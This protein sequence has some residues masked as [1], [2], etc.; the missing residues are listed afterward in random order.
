MPGWLTH[1]GHV[2]RPRQERKNKNQPR[3]YIPWIFVGSIFK[4]WHDERRMEKIFTATASWN[5]VIIL[6]PKCKNSV[7]LKHH[8]PRFVFHIR[9]ELTGY[10]L[11]GYILQAPD[12]LRLFPG[13][14]PCVSNHLIILLQDVQVKVPLDDYKC[15]TWDKII[16]STLEGDDTW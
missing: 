13:M 1:G 4:R 9:I 14:S 16:A 8:L 11:K 3:L 12:N 10:R 7:S 6:L 15:F 2:Q 5:D